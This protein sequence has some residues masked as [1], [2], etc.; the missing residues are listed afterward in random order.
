MANTSIDTGD[1]SRAPFSILFNSDDTGRG[2][3]GDGGRALPGNGMVYD[4]TSGGGGPGG[5]G[6]GGL[7]FCHG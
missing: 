6:E 5:G 3:L 1:G 2:D 4:S 7:F